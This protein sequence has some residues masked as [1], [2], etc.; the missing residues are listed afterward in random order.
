MSAICAP[1]THEHDTNRRRSNGQR[2]YHPTRLG[3]RAWVNCREQVHIGD[4]TRAAGC[5]SLS[6]T[7]GVLTRVNRASMRR[8]AVT[9]PA[10]VPQTA[11]LV[12]RWSP[13]G[14][15]LCCTVRGPR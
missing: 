10:M 15:L 2:C 8:S 7:D 11:H 3:D 4:C 1:P 14:Q 13:L 9:Q 6:E 12:Q 5:L